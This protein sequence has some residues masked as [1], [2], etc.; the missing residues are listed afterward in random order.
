MQ[1]VGLDL[2]DELEASD[3]LFM[4]S[5][6]VG[7]CGSDVLW[8]LGNV[9]P[10][11]KPGVWVHIHDIFP[12]FEYPDDWLHGGRHW[13]EAY[14]VRTFLQFNDRFNIKLWIPWACQQFES[15][16]KSLM[17]KCL[18]NTGSGIWISAI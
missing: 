2:F 6:Q 7:K 17:P 8:L 10:R 11:L 5:S 15:D 14:F 12:G 3:I 4:D 1:D 16:I 18:L 9:L 13:N